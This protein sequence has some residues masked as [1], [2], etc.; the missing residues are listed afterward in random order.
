MFAQLLKPVLLK[1]N[2]S[3][4]IEE[5]RSNKQKELRIIDIL[6]PTLSNH[7]LIIDPRVIINDYKTLSQRQGINERSNLSYSLF[8][9]MSRLTRE[10]GSLRHDD[11]LDALSMAVGYWVEQ[12]A[13]DIDEAGKELKDMRIERELQ[14][15]QDSIFGGKPKEELWF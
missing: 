15:F 11:R 2:Y 12:M 4:T 13:R 7:R 3:V 14:K 1:T 5:L 6:E 8:Y 9:Q 10:R